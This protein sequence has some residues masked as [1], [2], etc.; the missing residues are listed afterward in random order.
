MTPQELRSSFELW[1]VQTG[2]GVVWGM[3][4]FF[5]NLT[6]VKT[7]KLIDFFLIEDLGTIWLQ[8][9]SNLNE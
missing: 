2:K 7:I 4:L 9:F 1:W 3:K 5:S 6:W 8:F